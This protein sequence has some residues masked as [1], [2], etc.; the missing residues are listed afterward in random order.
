MEMQVAKDNV[1][2]E[3]AK[4]KRYILDKS[5]EYTMSKAADLIGI[6]AQALRSVLLGNPSLRLL[7]HAINLEIELTKKGIV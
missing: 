1:E 5:G 6:T 7:Q 2:H 4:A 3:L